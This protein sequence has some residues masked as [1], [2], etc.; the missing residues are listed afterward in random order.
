GSERWH[1]IQLIFGPAVEDSHVVALN[2]AGLTQRLAKGTEPCVI[3]LGR[4]SSKQTDYWH[5]RLL[6][7]RRER[8]C[9]RSATHQSY[10]FPSPHR[11]PRPRITAYHIA[12]G[13]VRHSKSG[14]RMSALGQK[15][16]WQR[17]L[18]MSAL[19]PKA[20][21]GTQPRDVRFVPKRTSEPVYSITSS[22]RPSRE[23][24]V[25][26][27]RAFADLRLIIISSFV[28]W[29]TGRSA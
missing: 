22:A 4:L 15:Q 9:R 20:D 29:T 24:G 13:V 10:E 26:R 17:L 3:S 8:P 27:P 25:L 19:P 1:A 5:C 18:L 21:I 14:R 12:S 23:S 6:R 2:V 16:T 11:A 7:A 28:A